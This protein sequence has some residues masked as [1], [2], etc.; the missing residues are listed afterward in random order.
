MVRF[1]DIYLGPS[2]RCNTAPD[3]G[4]VCILSTIDIGVEYAA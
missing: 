1:S 2:S 3:G 4:V